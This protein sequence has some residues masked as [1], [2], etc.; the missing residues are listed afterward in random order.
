MSTELVGQLKQ[1][2][3]F[4]SLPEDVVTDLSER[5]KP[6]DLEKDQVLFN[7]GDAGDALYILRSGRLKMVSKDSEGN[8]MVLNQVGPGA[9][10][11]EMALIDREPRSAGVIA[12]TNAALL[13]LSTE[14]FLN[15]L[16]AQPLMGLE[17]SRNLIKRLRFATTYI[18]NAIEWSQ[19]IAKGEYGFI[20]SVDE[21][22]LGETEN[23][24]DQERAKR[25]LGTFFQMVQ[26]IKA[27]EDELKKELVKLRVEIDQAR[28]QTDLAEITQ[29]EFFQNLQKK[30]K[31]TGD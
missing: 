6:V 11:G 23:S 26:D 25:F 24:S 22:R 14:D 20:E 21:S 7:K 27:R 28:R 8:E 9:V 4:K 29:S 13:R 17:I 31:K 3:L 18:E 10:I 16:S 2:E 30:K 19:L 15:T 1:F 5:F 12:L